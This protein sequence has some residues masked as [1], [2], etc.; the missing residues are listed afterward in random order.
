MEAGLKVHKGK[1]LLNSISLQRMAEELPLVTSIIA[2][3]CTALGRDVPCANERGAIAAE[4]LYNANEKGIDNDRIWF[5][6][7]DT[8]GA[9]SNPSCKNCLEF[10]SMLQDIAPRNQSSAYPMCLTGPDN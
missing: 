1:A 7:C 5:D 2:T 9:T 6:P 4:L 3:S 8:S 10:L